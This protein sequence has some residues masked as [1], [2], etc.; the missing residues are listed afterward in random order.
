MATTTSTYTNPIDGVT[1]QTN[2]I[3]SKVNTAVPTKVQ[4]TK[5]TTVSTLNPA[6]QDTLV[7]T[8]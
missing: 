7:P 3:T 2:A 5:T 6:D 1:S 8:D 4:P